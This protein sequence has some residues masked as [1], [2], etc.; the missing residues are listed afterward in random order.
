MSH[1]EVIGLLATLW[2]QAGQ[3]A[4]IPDLVAEYLRRDLLNKILGNSD[5]HGRNTAIIRGA[6]SFRLAP[7]YDLAPM[8]MDDEGI[9]RTT[10]WGAGIESAGQINWRAACESLGAIVVPDMAFER[11]RADAEQL[12]ALPDLLSASGLPDITMNHP[13]IALKHLDKR[14]QEWGLK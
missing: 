5:N 7:I 12:R 14:L 8:V 3:Q 11:L 9:T 6:D 10:K 4:Q 13:Q 2:A 1:L